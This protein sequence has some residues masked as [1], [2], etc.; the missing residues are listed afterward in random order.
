MNKSKRWV[1][2]IVVWE[3]AVT[4][5]GPFNAREYVEGYEPVIRKSIG[6]LLEEN[7]R[8]VHITATDDR[9]SKEYC[10]ADEMTTIPRGMV[11]EVILL[12]PVETPVPVE[13]ST[14]Q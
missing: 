4:C 12:A 2:C 13:P 11:I 9:T 3:D 14:P 7:S 1:P 10:N 6:F 8:Y 5:H